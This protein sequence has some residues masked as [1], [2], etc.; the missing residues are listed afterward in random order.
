MKL[1]STE[2]VTKFHPDKYA[3]QISDAIVTACMKED[4]NSH[5]GVET[6]VKGGTVV[7]AGEVT[8][9]ATI[10]Y[11][12]IVR[13]V[14]DKLRYRVDKI[15]NLITEQSPEINRAVTRDDTDYIGAGDQGIVFGYASAETP[16][17]LPFAFDIA[18][19]IVTAIENDV[20]NNPDSPL[21]GDGKTQV[22]I[23]LDT[24]KITMIVVSVCHK[25]EVPLYE[26]RN[27][28]RHILHGIAYPDKWNINPAGEWTV[29]GP[30]ADCGLTGRKLCCDQYGGFY[31]VGGGALSGKDVSKVD[32]T[33]TYMARTLAVLLVEKFKLRY[34]SVQMGFIIGR[35]TP[36]S[37]LAKG[38]DGRNYSSFL[39]EHFDLSVKGMIDYLDLYNR[40]FEEISEGC[41]FFDKKT[42]ELR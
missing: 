31:S 17:H 6:L 12:A 9:T 21:K 11:E 30:D 42:G 5:C 20:D 14:A 35:D 18:N 41:H 38:S 15:I 33:G 23:D 24:G 13:R 36:I 16:T 7:L 19:R 39:R 29:G 34:C 1:F 27:H 40:D 8:T 10:D 3:D 28:V 22:T 25:E 4:R 37:V 32:R 26:V 2:A